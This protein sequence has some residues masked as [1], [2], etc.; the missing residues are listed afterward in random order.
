MLVG[1][2][3]EIA[4]QWVM[5][6]AAG[7]AGLCGA[8]HAGSTNWLPAWYTL[9]PASDVDVMVVVSNPDQPGKRGK[10]VYRDVLLDVSY[11]SSDRLRSPDEVLGDYHLAGG[12]RTPSII[13]DPSGELTA[14][15]SAVSADYARRR[16]V[17]RRCE[18]ARR[19]VLEHLRSSSESAPLHEQVTAWLFGTGV[20]THVLL[21]AGLRNPTVRGR[22]VATRELLADCGRPEFHGTLLTL[23]GCDGMRRERVEQHLTALA[24]VFDVAASVIRTPFPFASDLTYAARPIAIDGSRDLIERGLH[25]E[26]VF[27]IVATYSRCQLVLH[28]D[29]PR[30]VEAEFSAGYLELLGDL[31]VASSADLRRRSQE[32]EEFLPRLWE[33][34]EAIMAANSSIED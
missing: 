21:V 17:E 16:W 20:T 19:R 23:L 27:W 24:S 32:V 14:L 5:E 4:R 3:R 15:Q 2:A 33:E 34:A 18:H 22:Y 31:G 29:A 7:V 26:A 13:L 9:P 10:L 28:H 6:E 11:V 30:K 8:Y 12:L 25:R 1:D